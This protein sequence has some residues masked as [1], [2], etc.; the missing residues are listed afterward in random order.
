[1]VVD[2]HSDSSPAAVER[3][4][5]IAGRGVTA[6]EPNLRNV[7]GLADVFARHRV[8]ALITDPVDV[9]ADPS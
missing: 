1:V 8:D 4:E 6:Y 3:V 9:R 7:S 5:T 2:D